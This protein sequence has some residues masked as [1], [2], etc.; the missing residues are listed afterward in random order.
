[1]A[2]HFYEAQGLGPADSLWGG[3][4]SGGPD[5]SNISHADGG[6]DAKDNCSMDSNDSERLRFLDDETDCL[7]VL[8]QRQQ[9]NNHVL[10]QRY[11]DQLHNVRVLQEENAAIM[12]MVAALQPHKF[13]FTL[14]PAENLTS[15]ADGFCDDPEPGIPAHRSTAAAGQQTAGFGSIPGH[16]KQPSRMH[17]NLDAHGTPQPQQHDAMQQD[18]DDLQDCNEAEVEAV[19]AAALAVNRGNPAAALIDLLN[20]ARK[21]RLM[22]DAGV[23][24]VGL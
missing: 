13:S 10:Q 17:E 8:L 9:A 15:L 12:R 6:A 4:L 16:L 21:R 24:P 23:Q 11:Q 3:P 7:T 20:L 1:M 2:G 5:L 22:A 19:A 14:E 18:E